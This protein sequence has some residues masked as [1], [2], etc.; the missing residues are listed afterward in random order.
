VEP[1]GAWWWTARGAG[2]ARFLRLW[3]SSVWITVVKFSSVQFSG[4][5]IPSLAS[6]HG[7][8]VHVRSRISLDVG[9]R[10]R[11]LDESF[12][13]SEHALRLLFLALYLVAY[14]DAISGRLH[15][16]LDKALA[17]TTFRRW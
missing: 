16:A 1:S 2:F 4:S 7:G 14:P 9:S 3:L 11:L 12:S 8:F 6:A 5:R 13:P 17:T 15:R 10:Y